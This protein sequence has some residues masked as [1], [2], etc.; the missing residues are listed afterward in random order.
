MNLVYPNRA[1]IIVPSFD[2]VALSI[3]YEY[4]SSLIAIHESF[5]IQFI[6]PS[7]PNPSDHQKTCPHE[8]LR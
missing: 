4:P 5:A 6:L 2:R 1:T 3:P 7:K 8:L